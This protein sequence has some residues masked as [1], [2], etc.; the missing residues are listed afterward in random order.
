MI[1]TP[2]SYTGPAGSLW[3]ATE[4]LARIPAE[5]ALKQSGLDKVTQ[6]WQLTGSFILDEIMLGITRDDSISIATN[7][8]GQ[9]YTT[10]QV[11]R[12]YRKTAAITY[13]LVG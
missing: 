3:D 12:L 7:I 6:K 8:N 5:W 10:V 2:R 4:N 13:Y 1:S 9:N 11:A